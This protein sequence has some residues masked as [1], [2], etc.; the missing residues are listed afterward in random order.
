ML[1]RGYFLCIVLRNLYFKTKNLSSMSKAINAL[2]KKPG[3]VFF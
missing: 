2:G 3:S 1:P